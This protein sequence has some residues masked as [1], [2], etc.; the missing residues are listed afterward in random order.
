M[1]LARFH[2]IASVGRRPHALQPLALAVVS[3][4]ATCVRCPH[5]CMQCCRFVLF[6]AENLTQKVP[7]FSTNRQPC[8]KKSILA[9]V[10]FG[11]KGD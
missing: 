8:R 1:L 6:S 11:A 9:K 2:D 10:S 5:A 7:F 4:R 3:V